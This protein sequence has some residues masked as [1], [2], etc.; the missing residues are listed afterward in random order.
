MESTHNFTSTGN[1]VSQSHT[2]VDTA[3]SAVL[4]NIKGVNS[5]INKTG[6]SRKVPALASYIES[7]AQTHGHNGLKVFTLTKKQEQALEEEDMIA[8]FEQFAEVASR[9]GEAPRDVYPYNAVGSSSAQPS[10]PACSEDSISTDAKVRINKV[11]T[12]SIMVGAMS[13]EFVPVLDAQGKPV[14][15]ETNA[16]VMCDNKPAVCATVDTLCQL[17]HAV[18]A[19]ANGI[20]S[21]A[22]NWGMC[23][24]SVGYKVLGGSKGPLYISCHLADSE[25]KVEGWYAQTMC[26]HA[27]ELHLKTGFRLYLI[28]RKFEETI[29]DPETGKLIVNKIG[30]IKGY[31]AAASL[32]RAYKFAANKWEAPQFAYDWSNLQLVEFMRD[33]HTGEIKRTGCWSLES[34]PTGEYLCG[35][36]E[37]TRTLEDGTKVTQVENH[38][39]Q[40]QTNA[41]DKELVAMWSLAQ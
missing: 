2:R 37:V 33:S 16:P 28:N 20:V 3:I 17:T 26:K 14:H 32:R 9:L 7:Y 15:D 4:S 39:I 40:Q 30:E 35:P 6:D 23:S 1:G 13:E 12:S 19:D 21:D 31:H 38:C 11:G 27:Q 25:T 22:N 5:I 18:F 41:T 24:G 29:V 10:T 36:I 8:N 34:I